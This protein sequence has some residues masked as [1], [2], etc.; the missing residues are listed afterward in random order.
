M[1]AGKTNQAAGAG[2]HRRGFLRALG[3]ASSVAV[4]AVATSGDVMAE[5]AD[6]KKTKARF[7]DSDHVKTYYKVNRY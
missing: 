4:A 7:K 6:A 3:G 5:E 1:K 2:L